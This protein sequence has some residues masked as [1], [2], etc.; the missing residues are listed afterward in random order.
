VAGDVEL[1]GEGDGG[2]LACGCGRAIGGDAEALEF[3]LEL[4][5][6]GGE[7]PG[8]GGGDGGEDGEL[9]VAA[10]VALFVG[11]EGGGTL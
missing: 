6:A 2:S 5:D 9:A 3:S 8:L 4:E 10:A 11:G 7:L 1:V